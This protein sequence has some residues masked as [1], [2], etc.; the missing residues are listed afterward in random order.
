MAQA[1]FEVLEGM[2]IL[3]TVVF[4]ALNLMITSEKSSVQEHG[5]MC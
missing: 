1:I 4:T 2:N 5:D 3:V